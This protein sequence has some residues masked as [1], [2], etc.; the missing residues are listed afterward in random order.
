MDVLEVSK[1]LSIPMSEIDISAVRSQGA[2]GQNV[3]K[4]ATAIHL[5]F[6]IKGSASLPDEL[7]ARLLQMQDKRINTDG[8][9]IIKSQ[10]HRSQ[11]RNRQSALRRLSDLLQKSLRTPKKRIPTTPGKKA[12]QKR[13]DDKARRGAL[14]KTR[15]SFN[16]E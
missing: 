7:K 8:V 5:R 10:R 16:E 4:V 1:T 6:D 3:N 14:K 13:L 2:G 12:T 11:E 15:S 9:L